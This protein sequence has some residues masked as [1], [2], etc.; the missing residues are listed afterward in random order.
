MMFSKPAGIEPSL[1]GK[2]VIIVGSN[3]LKR[4]FESPLKLSPLRREK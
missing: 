1:K 4:C 2:I 3:R